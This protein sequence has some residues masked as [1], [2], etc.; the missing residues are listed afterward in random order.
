MPVDVSSVALMAEEDEG[1]KS[2][3]FEQNFQSAEDFALTVVVE[4]SL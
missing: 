1:R 2:G 3:D 4:S